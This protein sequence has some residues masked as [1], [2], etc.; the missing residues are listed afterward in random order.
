MMKKE[1]LFLHKKNKKKKFK[2][3]IFKNNINKKIFH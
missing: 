3:N 2:F 1:T